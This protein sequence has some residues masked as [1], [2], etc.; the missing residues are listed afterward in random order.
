MPAFPGEI[1]AAIEEGIIIETLISP[2]KFFNKNGRI[3][4]VGCIRN[5][6]T[7]FDSSGRKKPVAIKG[8]DFTTEV[9]TIITAIGEQPDLGNNSFSGIELRVNGIFKTD[10]NMMISSTP[11]VF[12]G[13]DLITGPNTA[14]DAIGAGKRAAV[15]ID[16]YIR[17]KKLFRAQSEELPKV[18]IKPGP[19]NNQDFIQ[20]RRIKSAKA[21][22]PL[23]I[24]SLEEVELPYSEKDAAKEANRCLR[25]DLKYT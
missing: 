19:E 7:D 8:S 15:N 25:C 14:V 20:P 18:H 17:G 22:V 13:G 24:K 12:A 10:Q 5:R 6:L 16:Y 9:N 23:R 3:L 11:G 4:K 1:E 21:D 2:V